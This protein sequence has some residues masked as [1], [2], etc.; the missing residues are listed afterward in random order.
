MP[1]RI[2]AIR[3]VPRQEVPQL[4]VPRIPRNV[5]ERLPPPVTRQTAP[6]VTT[7]LSP[8]VVDVPQ[9]DVPAYE[10]PD[11][12]PEEM[13][14]EERAPD[15]GTEKPESPEESPAEHPRETP[16]LPAPPPT[17]EPP[18][19][20]EEPAVIEVPFIEYELPVPR[21]EQVA[22]AG[23]TAAAS[24]AATLLGK[25][26]VDQLV[27]VLKPLLK[28]L[29]LRARQALARDLTPYETQ[30]ILAFDQEKALMKRLRKEQ[31]AERLKQAAD[32]A[33]PQHLRIL[34][35]KETEDG[36]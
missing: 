14:I 9:A 15:P 2:P 34:R 23:T 25:A 31:K 17:P 20:K 4:E 5:I 36:T 10:P 33:R 7:Q 26:L 24:V 6:P 16:D 13:V 8:P 11:F 29:L 22:L 27:K 28:Q 12:T 3:P 18:P 19:R 21:A 1:E 32:F 30:Q 35:R